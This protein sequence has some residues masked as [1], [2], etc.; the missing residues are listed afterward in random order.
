MTHILDVLSGF[1]KF[2]DLPSFK[3]QHGIFWIQQ[4][5]DFQKNRLDLLNKRLHQIELIF[6]IIK[7]LDPQISSLPDPPIPKPIIH[8]KLER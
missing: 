2:R 3:F 4:I 8:I 7:K 6:E 5:I 1:P